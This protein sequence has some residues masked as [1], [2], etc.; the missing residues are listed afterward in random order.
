MG[1]SNLQS[2]SLSN[3][4]ISRLLLPIHSHSDPNGHHS[5]PPT[6]AGSTTANLQRLDLRN[7]RLRDVDRIDC[8]FPNLRELDLGH[9]R[10]QNM[11]AFVQLL[12]GCTM[13]Y[14]VEL[15]MNPIF[16]RHHAPLCLDHIVRHSD[17]IQM[18]GDLN[19][20]ER[21]RQHALNMLLQ[22]NAS[23]SA[24]TN[25][26]VSMQSAN[27]P[28]NGGSQSG[29]APAALLNPIG[30]KIQKIKQKPPRKAMRKK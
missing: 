5:G 17:S 21:R 10:I 25:N 18:V 19:L 11:A 3:N 26:A 8:F 2:L 29:T 6:A 12:S 13:L 7:N 23:S 1:S 16:S 9:N 4:K 22:Q 14:R 30:L 15:E 27:T 24:S 20:A 28:T